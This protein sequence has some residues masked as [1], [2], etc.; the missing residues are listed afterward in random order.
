[1]FLPSRRAVWTVVS[2]GE[3]IV[4]LD[5]PSCTCPYFFFNTLRGRRGICKHLRALERAVYWGEYE[6]VL[7]SD[8]ELEML[9]RGILKD[10][11]ISFYKGRAP[12]AS[13]APVA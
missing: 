7:G 1:M 12:A 11:W 8:D 10:L 4:S 3:Y 13:G 9:L 6:I 5:P 2:G